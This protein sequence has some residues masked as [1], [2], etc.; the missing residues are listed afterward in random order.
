[1]EKIVLIE[2]KKM[3][4]EWQNIKALNLIQH[5]LYYTFLVIWAF[6]IT[7]SQKKLLRSF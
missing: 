1:M 6:V 5:N 3:R 4:M 7:E 2:T